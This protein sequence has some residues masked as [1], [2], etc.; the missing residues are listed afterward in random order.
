MVFS[1]LYSLINDSAKVRINYTIFVDGVIKID[2]SLAVKP[3][4]PNIP[5]V[6]MQMG[7]ERSYDNIEWFGR[8]PF[9]NYIDKRYAADVGIYN[10]TVKDFMENYVVPQENGNRT[11]VRWMYLSDP[12][13]K[14][15]LLVV[16]DSLLSMSA[17]PYTDSTI[18]NAKHTN[19]LKDA[20]FIALNIDLIQMGVGGND[21]WSEVAAPL[22]QYQIK[23]RPYHYRFYIVP[24][25]AK[26]KTAGE[27]AKEIKY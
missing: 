16:A 22:E 23:A 15:G 26:N 21:S 17:W 4:L 19:K 27:R 11:D 7:I 20:G 24:V 6:G 12:K 25:N 18:Q 10:F 8:G 14:N 2:Y 13:T 3:G 5:K 9:E 1:N